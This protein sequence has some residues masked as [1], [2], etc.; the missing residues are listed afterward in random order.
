MPSRNVSL[1]SLAI[2]FMFL[3]TTACERKGPAEKAGKEIDRAE[4]SAKKKYDET[5]K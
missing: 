2:M 5:T 4:D 1:I 3:T